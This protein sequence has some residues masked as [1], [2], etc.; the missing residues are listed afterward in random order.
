MNIFQR[1]HPFNEFVY[2][3]WISDL[4][5]L[6]KIQVGENAQSSKRKDKNNF[7]WKSSTDS[8]DSTDKTK[9]PIKT[10]LFKRS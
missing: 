6:V 10:Q 7:L 9:K 2:E 1:S 3:W 5:A 8:T 4:Y